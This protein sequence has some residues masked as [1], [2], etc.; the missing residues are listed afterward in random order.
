MKFN[1]D[2]PITWQGVVF[3][4]SLLVA[5]VAGGL[6]AS[7]FSPQPPVGDVLWMQ[8]WSSVTLVI[9]LVAAIACYRAIKRMPDPT[10]DEATVESNREATQARMVIYGPAFLLL[11][12]L[13]TWANYA[14]TRPGGTF[15]V[16]VGMIFF[17]LVATIAG[18]LRKSR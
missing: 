3:A 11:G 8:A 16:P 1:R 5:F 14:N 6:L 9:C 17:G 10:L 7:T 18:L 4:V 12:L 15:L 2:M 13:T